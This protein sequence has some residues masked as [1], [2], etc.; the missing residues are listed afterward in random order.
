[1]KQESH[2]AWGNK[3]EEMRLWHLLYETLTETTSAQPIVSS[4]PQ[5][6][7]MLYPQ[8]TVHNKEFSIE[9]SCVTQ[10]QDYLL[11]QP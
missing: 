8:G 5:P 6:N 3:E 2:K 9:F 1:M 11:I 7:S 4:Y 10:I